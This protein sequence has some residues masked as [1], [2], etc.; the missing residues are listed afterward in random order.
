MT[1]TIKKETLKETLCRFFYLIFLKYVMK[2][3]SGTEAITKTSKCLFYDER[4]TI[5]IASITIMKTVV[6]QKHW[7]LGHGWLYE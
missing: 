7:P 6:T 1:E 2:K 4:R 5:F 3:F